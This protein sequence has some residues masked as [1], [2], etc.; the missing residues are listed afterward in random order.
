[1]PHNKVI[2]VDRDAH[3]L[4]HF[5]VAE[6][7]GLVFVN[8][9]AGA[10]PLSARLAGIEP[11]L[12]V[13]DPESLT[14]VSVG[15][16]ELWQANWK[17]I[18][19]NAM[20]S[21]HLFKVHRETLERFSPT[22]D[23]YYLA[24]SSEWSLTGGATQREKGV[25][26]TLLGTSEG[27]ALDHYILVSIPPSFVGVLAYGSFG[28]LSAHPVDANTTVVRSGSTVYPG[29]VAHSASKAFT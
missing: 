17:L 15:E 22:R 26:E 27:D 10:Q 8:L 13:F 18:M 20:E 24:G 16:T 1:M 29:Q 5:Q 9:D 21:Y 4:A 25:L 6:W 2:A 11:Y 14:D 19:E 7:L 23:A 3:G 28:W 12:A